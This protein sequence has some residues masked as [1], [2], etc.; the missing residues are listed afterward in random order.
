MTDSLSNLSEFGILIPKNDWTSNA[1]PFIIGRVMD[2]YKPYIL[3]LYVSDFKVI[4]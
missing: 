2:P 1:V 3:I 4:P